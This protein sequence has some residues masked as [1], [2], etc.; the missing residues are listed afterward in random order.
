MSFK[1]LLCSTKSSDNLSDADQDIVGTTYLASGV[2]NVHIR[3]PARKTDTP[4][5]DA[6]QSFE[7]EKWLLYRP[8]AAF[9]WAG[10]TIRLLAIWHLG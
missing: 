7:F 10:E 4:C 2:I 8:E 6:A 5:F 9:W 3:M 1:G